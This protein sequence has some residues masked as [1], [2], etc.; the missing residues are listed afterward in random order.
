MLISEAA[1]NIYEIQP[2]GNELDRFPLCT[3]YF[4]VDEKTALVETGSSAQIPDILKAG[5]I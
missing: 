4:V 3:V 2:E 1:E 5:G